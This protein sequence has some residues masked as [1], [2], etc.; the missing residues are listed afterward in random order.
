MPTIRKH[1]KR[2]EL[3]VEHRSLD[4]DVMDNTLD[5]TTLATISL[6]EARL[7]RIEHILYGPASPPPKPP[8][9]PVTASLAKLERRFAQLVRQYRVYAEILKICTVPSKPPTRRLPQD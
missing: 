7:L 9:E 4:T 8:A 5:Q 3:H 6:L 2:I 1:P